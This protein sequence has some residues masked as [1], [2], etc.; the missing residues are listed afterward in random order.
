[1]IACAAVQGVHF[2]LVAC[3]LNIATI[4]EMAIDLI[5]QFAGQTQE[6]RVRLG[7]ELSARIC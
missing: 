2:P 3:E 4:I 1:M 6:W 5:A 7:F